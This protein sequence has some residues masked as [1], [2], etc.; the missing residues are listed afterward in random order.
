MEGYNDLYDEEED[1]SQF[2]DSFKYGESDDEKQ[3]DEEVEVNMD[4]LQ[5]DQE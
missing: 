4:E 1:G 3:Q 2:E 5:D